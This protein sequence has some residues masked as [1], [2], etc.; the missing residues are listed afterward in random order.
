MA[1]EREVLSRKGVCRQQCYGIACCLERRTLD[2][3]GASSNPGRSGGRIFFSTELTFCADSYSVSVPPLCY[4]SGTSFCQKC[5]WPVSPKHAYTLDPTKS[6][7]AD[8][9]AVQALCG[10]LSGNEL[11]RNLSG[12]TRPQSS[13]LAEPRWT[14]TGPVSYTHLTLPTRPL[15]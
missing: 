11:T 5:R 9:A 13:Q 6:V 1:G 14:D 15:V 7:W 12:N 4:C 3:K 2:R 10:N 8:Y